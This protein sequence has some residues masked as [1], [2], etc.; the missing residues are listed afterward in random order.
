MQIWHT[1]GRQFSHLYIIYYAIL[2]HEHIRFLRLNW[3]KQ[4]LQQ[5]AQS[6]HIQLRQ[7]SC[8]IIE[9]EEE[10]KK[11]EATSAKKHTKCSQISHNSSLMVV[12]VRSGFSLPLNPKKPVLY[13]VFYWNKDFD[14]SPSSNI[15]SLYSLY[16]K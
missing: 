3:L 6:S 13:Y 9:R 7:E 15:C 8:A 11:K 14:F 2:A 4:T 12:C 16:Q 5:M 1:V 10:Y